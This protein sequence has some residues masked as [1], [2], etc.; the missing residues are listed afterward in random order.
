MSFL[1]T[2]FVAHNKTPCVHSEGLVVVYVCA[3]TTLQGRGITTLKSTDEKY[4]QEIRTEQLSEKALITRY[5]CHRF[6]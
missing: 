5:T 3:V 1:F 4:T 2:Q 6:S